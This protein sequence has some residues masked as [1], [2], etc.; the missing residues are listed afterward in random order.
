M[1][2]ATSADR[3]EVEK[4]H[5]GKITTCSSF[6]SEILPDRIV[7]LLSSFQVLTGVLWPVGGL[8]GLEDSP[9]PSYIFGFFCLTK[10]EF[11]ADMVSKC[12]GGGGLRVQRQVHVEKCAKS[13]KKGGSEEF[14][15]RA[16]KRFQ[17]D[18]RFKRLLCMQDLKIRRT[19]MKSTRRTRRNVAWCNFAHVAIFQPLCN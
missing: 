11:L 2:R 14:K 3:T 8:G 18:E 6:S 4:C 17:E 13:T 15:D 16:L 1:G 7:T 10:H 19:M 9:R 12:N 5:V